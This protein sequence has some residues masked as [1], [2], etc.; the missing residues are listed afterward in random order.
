VSPLRSIGVH[1][2][3]CLPFSAHPIHWKINYGCFAK[4]NRGSS[5][6]IEKILPDKSD[7]DIDA[8]SL[9]ISK[10]GFINIRILDLI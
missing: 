9:L 6:E 1:H 2:F 4:E 8:D 3:K 5:A 7:S 10:I